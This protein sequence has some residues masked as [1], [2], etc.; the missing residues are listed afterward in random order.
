[1]ALN[2]FFYFGVGVIVLAIL[3]THP[4]RSG[5][6]AIIGLIALAASF[7]LTMADMLTLRSL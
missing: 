7:I 4:K 6:L 2:P 3:D 1:M 5:A